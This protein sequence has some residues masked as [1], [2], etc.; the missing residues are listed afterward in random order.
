MHTLRTLIVAAFGALL[1]AGSA[2]VSLAQELPRPKVIAVQV[3]AS[4]CEPCLDM[5][6]AVGHLADRF[7]GEP[8]LGIVLD[9]TDLST[10]YHASLLAGALDLDALY[11]EKQGTLGEVYLLDGESKAL[12]ETL[13]EADDF[14]T[15]S[16]KVRKALASR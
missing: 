6:A 7:D 14:E 10:K 12:I 4:W 8:I 1:L 11:R 9:V 2:T 13:T 5:E 15:M 16:A 3:F